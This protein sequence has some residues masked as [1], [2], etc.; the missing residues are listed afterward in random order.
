VVVKV[1]KGWGHELIIHN[2]E[3]YCGK[4]L[5]FNAQKRCSLHYHKLKCETFY[6]QSGR[7]LLRYRELN[8]TEEKEVL[9]QAG[10]KFEVHPGLVHQM[11]ACTDVELF[12][13]S[14]QH[15]DDDSYRITLG[16]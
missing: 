13:F 8:E 15:F 9:L 10:D 16:D 14:T 7:L 1:N 2:D 6:V 11:L 12:E 5:F 4:L 3:K